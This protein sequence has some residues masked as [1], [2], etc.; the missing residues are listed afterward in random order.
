MLIYSRSCATSLV[1]FRAATWEYESS[2][3]LYDEYVPFL[4]G[5]Y[6]DIGVVIYWPL[7]NQSGHG[8]Y[9]YS[10]VLYCIYV[11]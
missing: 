5:W 9:K 7:C 4:M 11:P 1:Q 3:L 8:E 6:I 2:G 10:S